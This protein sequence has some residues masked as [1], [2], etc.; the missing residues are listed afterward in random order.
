MDEG[1]S[2]ILNLGN[3]QDAETRRRMGALL[4]VQIEQAALSRTDLAPEKRRP[5]TVLVDEMSTTRC[6]TARTRR[7]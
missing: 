3:I 5:W 6:Q 1:K 4:L 2:L 7:R